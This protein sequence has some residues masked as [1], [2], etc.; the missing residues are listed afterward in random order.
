[1]VR[2]LPKISHVEQ[3]CEA[4]IA[5][6]HRRKPFPTI[7][8]Y[9]ATEPLELVHGDLCGPITP[10]THGGKRYF[11]LLV[12]D[13]SKYMWLILL[14]TKDEAAAAIRR[15]QATVEK[16]SRRP[17]RVLRTDRGGEFTAT[18][19]A[20]WCADHDIKRH[21]IAP[22]SPQQNGVVERRN[23]TV[24]GATRCMLKAMNM[25]AEF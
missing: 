13:H 18:D 1:M 17:L 16:E 7:A 22:Y 24:V 2:G 11:L 15:F 20:D 12:D 10:A 5:G 23:Q 21:L 4:C 9:R 19:F 8:K 14:K 3:L 6:K 25:P